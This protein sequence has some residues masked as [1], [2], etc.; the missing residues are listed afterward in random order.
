MYT[1]KVENRDTHA[2]PE[3]SQEFPPETVEFA[4]LFEPAL[5][6]QQLRVFD[7]AELTPRQVVQGCR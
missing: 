7:S 5:Y 2:A 1:L 6:A 4:R 3:L